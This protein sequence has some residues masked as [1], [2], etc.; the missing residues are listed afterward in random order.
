MSQG[1]YK[2][3]K[4]SEIQKLLRTQ[5]T[6]EVATGI[7]TGYYS[8]LFT[9]MKKDGT[10][11]TIPNL[12]KFNEHCT[13]EHFK[14]ESIKN[15]INML[16]PGM[17]L[18]P[19]DIKD[20]FYCF[21]LSWTYLWFIWKEKI[22]QFL[23]IPNGYIDVM[24]IFNKLLKLVLKLVIKL[25]YTNL[26]MNH[27]FMRMI[28]CCWPRHFKNVLIMYLPQCPC[29]RNWGL[30]YTQQS[31]YIFVPTQKITFLG[32]ENDNLNMTLTLTSTK[33]ENIRN[34]SAV[35]L[36]KQSCSIMVWWW[37]MLLHKCFGIT[38]SWISTKSLPK[39]FQ[40]KACQDFSDNTT[41]VRHK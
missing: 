10:Y 22:H 3:L 21:A 36:L 25:P 38:S 31:L 37:N 24:Q 1:L 28:N 27:L 9:N 13:K 29:Y 32:F 30:S 6:E 41:A 12:K 23:A 15:V 8:N 4:N 33:R 2:K 18:A 40:E 7:N 35:L 5:V 19:I 39:R 16:K 26:G 14:L 17:F 11:R 34:V 20:V